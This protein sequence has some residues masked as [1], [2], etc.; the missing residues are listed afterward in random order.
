M[1]SIFDG[2]TGI[3]TG[4]L[5]DP[6]ITW[7][8]VGHD[9]VVVESIFRLSPVEVGGAD[10]EPVMA[11]TPVWRVPFDPAWPREPK[12]GDII[13]PGDG[14]SYRILWKQPSGSPAAD[15]FLLFGL[16]LVT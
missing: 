2:L 1:T 6:G 4:V 16:E 5:G 3:L 15:H 14:K 13:Q 10:G 7:L 9:A 11:M 12:R 8:P